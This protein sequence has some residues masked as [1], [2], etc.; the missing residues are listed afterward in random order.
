MSLNNDVPRPF[1][2]LLSGRPVTRKNTRWQV[3]GEVF[4]SS[5]WLLPSLPLSLNDQH[6]RF[7]PTSTP[8]LLLPPSPTRMSAPSSTLLSQLLGE[9]RTLLALEGRLAQLTDQTRWK[10]QQVPIAPRAFG[11]LHDL[12]DPATVARSCYREA[13]SCRSFPLTSPAAEGEL[14]H[15]NDLRV[16]LG[17]GWW[18]EMTA[19]QAARFVGRKREGEPFTPS[20]FIPVK[21]MVEENEG[22]EVEEGNPRS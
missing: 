5:P 13:D 10:G 3:E 20:G 17:D 12:S 7:C 22:R 4:A 21:L 2:S 6:R 18:V 15:T 16:H 19:K 14:I 1:G 9:E 11:E 8:S